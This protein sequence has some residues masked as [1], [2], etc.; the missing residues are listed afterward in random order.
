MTN[1][2]FN[3]IDMFHFPLNDENWRAKTREALARHGCVAFP[4]FL[5]P[6]ALLS[7]QKEAA[8]GIDKAYFNPQ[9]HTIY[10]SPPDKNF[11][12]DHIR[13]RMV[14]SSK[15]CITDDQIDGSS[16]LKQLYH[17]PLFK[18]ALCDILGESALFPYADTLSSV[19]IHY[20]RKGEELGWHFDNSSFAV[21]LM[22]S[23]ASAGGVFEFVRDVRNTDADD[24]AFETVDDIVS[25]RI[26]PSHINM[27]AGALL[28]F[29]G[30]NAL[31]RVT[32][33]LDN[34]V[35][36]LAVLAYNQEPDIALSET[37]QK[38]FYGR[39]GEAQ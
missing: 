15:G 21:T 10:L 9:Y 5:R 24:M 1:D 2:L 23:P 11:D 25:G 39:V 3:L 12:E 28:L 6:E 34:S 32:P 36:Q 33:V 7:L 19:N 8:A 20:A 30:R 27:S 17:A 26:S 37:A 22:I 13:N 31:H 4:D 18:E 38:T 14:L 29:R 16:V 35:R